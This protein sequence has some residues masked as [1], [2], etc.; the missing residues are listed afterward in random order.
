MEHHSLHFTSLSLTSTYQAGAL[1]LPLA[2]LK[3]AWAQN[4]KHYR[5]DSSNSTTQIDSTQPFFVTVFL[6]NRDTY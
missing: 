5:R 6:S 2:Q 1:R 4:V 3:E